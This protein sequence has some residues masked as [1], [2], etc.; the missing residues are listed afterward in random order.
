[1]AQG[2]EDAEARLS[3]IHFGKVEGE[4]MAKIPVT[5]TTAKPMGL[6]VKA[7]TYLHNL[8]SSFSGTRP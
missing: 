8:L 6:V 1:M 7:A 5:P 2:F 4:I 3:A